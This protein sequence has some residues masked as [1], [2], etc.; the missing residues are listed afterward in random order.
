MILKKRH[1]LTNGYMEKPKDQRRSLEER[2]KR[3]ARTSRQEPQVVARTPQKTKFA[4][5]PGAYTLVIVKGQDEVSPGE[6]FDIDVYITGYGTIDGV[7]LL[8][9]GPTNIFE[10][11]SSEV[12]H[13]LHKEYWEWGVEKTELKDV[14]PL[15]VGI[16]L[17]R[18]EEESAKSNRMFDDSGQNEVDPR[19]NIGILP[20]ERFLEQP[21]MSFRLKI[22]HKEKVR[23]GLHEINFY[24]TY[25][26]GV[27]WQNNVQTSTILVRN[28]VQRNETSLRVAGLVAVL[29]A[30]LSFIVNIIS[31]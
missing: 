28:W 13:G 8:I 23:T 24:L 4:K 10:P 22:L 29:I 7:K 30:L 5:Y 31:N 2:A 21:P 11:T 26:D 1:L 25:F 14:D 9:Y 15:F 17:T 27:K 6:Y 12:V 16:V 20:T 3:K 19:G 18:F